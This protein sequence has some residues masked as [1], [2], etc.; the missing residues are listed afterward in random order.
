MKHFTRGFFF[1]SLTTL[2]VIVSG[3]LAFHK[4]VIKP[5]EEEETKFDEEKW[6]TTSYAGSMT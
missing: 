2:G 6:E 4:T 5:I 1:G 3:A